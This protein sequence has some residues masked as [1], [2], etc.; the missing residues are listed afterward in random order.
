MKPTR[1]IACLL[2]LLVSLYQGCAGLNPN[3][4]VGLTTT[5][6]LMQRGD[7]EGARSTAEPHAQQGEPWA[8][9]RLGMIAIDQRCPKGTDALSWLMKAATYRAETP[10]EKGSATS[11]SGSTGYFNTRASSTNAAIALGNI[12]TAN[13]YPAMKWYWI[14]RAASQYSPDEKDGDN[15]RQLAQELGKAIP[16][17]DQKRIAEQ[18]EV[19]QPW[20][21]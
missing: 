8:Q 3:N 9:Y 5:D 11:I 2:L 16:S 19:K 6:F 21:K 1:T 7:C 15:L 4:N 12:F 17:E 14:Q 20:H 13:G 10:W 18:W